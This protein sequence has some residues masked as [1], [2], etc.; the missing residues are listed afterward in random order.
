MHRAHSILH[1]LDGEYLLQVGDA[2]GEFRGGRLLQIVALTGELDHRDHVQHALVSVE[3]R[4]DSKSFQA[5][6]NTSSVIDSVISTCV[7]SGAMMTFR[8][9]LASVEGVYGNMRADH[10]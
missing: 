8:I 1:D 7:I 3:G 9:G 4:R 10:P 5:H 6:E 2:L